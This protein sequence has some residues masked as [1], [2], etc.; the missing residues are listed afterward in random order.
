MA[1]LSLQSLILAIALFSSS[2]SAIN[3]QL[4][5]TWS[6]KSGKVLTGPGF[7]N[8]INDS[9]I[10]PSHTGISYSFTADGHYEE[11]YYRT[12]SNP[13]SPN[14]PQAVMQWQHGTFTETTNTSLILTP[15]AVDGR[16]LVSDPCSSSTSTYT[17]YNQAETIKTYQVYTDSYYK[18]LRL[19]LYE[20]DGTPMNPMYLA[21]DPPLM[22]PTITMN[23]TGTAK[24]T[25]T[26]VASSTANAK[27]EYS[28]EDEFDLPLN[29][30]AS[31]IK[32]DDLQPRY[33]ANA[34]LVWWIGV[35]MSLLGGIA[36]L[37]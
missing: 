20:W 32:R 17:R 13:T 8:P 12:V 22:L 31:H 35:G 34:G 18:I 7:F 16:Q 36:Y 25:S 23:P 14:C 1:V 33:L 15:F 11:A 26:A 2:S 5:G 30:Y 29:K 27:R 4:V 28:P 24:S 19:D 21:Y 6:T 10:E 3:S 9:L 37:L